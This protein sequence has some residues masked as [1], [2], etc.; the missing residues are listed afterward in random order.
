MVEVSNAGRVVFPE[1]GITKGDVVAY[2]ERVAPRALPH[3]EGRPLSIRRFPKG[4]AAPGF[5]QKNVP[6][7]YPA[8]MDR[9]TVPRSPGA[10]KRRPK[11][12]DDGEPDVT[13][14]PVV[15][16]AEHLAFLANQGAI[17]LHVPTARA[18]DL[19]QPDRVVFDLDPPTGAT[20]LVRRAA[21][22]ARAFLGELGLET[23]L[24]ATGSKGYHLVG[25]LGGAL[26]AD[27]VLA[28]TQKAAELLAAHAPEVMTTAF[29]VVKRGKRVFVDWL[30]NAPLATVVAPYSLRAR[31]GATV[32]VPLAWD[33]LDAR[34]PDAFG[35]RDLDE[36]LA[37]PDPLL[38]L[39]PSDGDA[40][41][42]RVDAAFDAAGL[43]LTQFDRFRS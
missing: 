17:E 14:Y 3:L 6:P 43:V 5:F 30:R 32:A 35:L 25:R 29:R 16:T 9:V 24:V 2:Y 28:T 12:I 13:V 37:R 20:E 18:P 40:F 19:H 39:A 22:D 38:A 33:E 8:S 15:H 36:L 27:R 31:P 7:H 41:A 23:A 10:A 34:A 42:A 26:T 4:L 11:A 21:R 1:V